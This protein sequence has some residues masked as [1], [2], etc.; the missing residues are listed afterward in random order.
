VQRC[1]SDAATTE[2]LSISV[3]PAFRSRLS[4]FIQ[5]L[6]QSAGADFGELRR[7]CV[8]GSRVAESS[9]SDEYDSDSASDAQEQL[10][11]Q[12]ELDRVEW[13]KESIQPCPRTDAH[14]CG[15]VVEQLHYPRLGAIARRHFRS[16]F[17]Q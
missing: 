7:L 15:D 17:T 6:R 1:S 14:C 13:E 9:A 11:C 2:P 16:L 10:P 4:N 8:A 3:T 5:D 12:L